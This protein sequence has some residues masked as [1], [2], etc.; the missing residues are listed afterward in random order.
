MS[1]IYYYHKIGHKKNEC[2]SKN[3]MKNIMSFNP[4]VL[5]LVIQQYQSQQQ[6]YNNSNYHHPQYYACNNT[7]GKHQ[8]NAILNNFDPLHDNNNNN[9]R[10]INN[11]NDKSF[12]TVSSFIDSNKNLINLYICITLEIKDRH[13]IP[14]CP[15]SLLLHP[16]C[17]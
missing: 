11:H 4:V 15:Q 2:Q 5:L 6:S 1:A 9:I 7:A 13:L 12:D 14:S 16:A 17:L 3:G 10:I 8:V